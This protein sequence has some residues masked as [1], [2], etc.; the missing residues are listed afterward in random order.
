MNLE[1]RIGKLEA[2]I[3]DE[4]S[5]WDLTLLTDAELVALEACLS[6][7]VAAGFPVCLTPELEAAM[8]RLRLKP[9]ST[10]RL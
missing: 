4:P 2:S 7:A 10:A 5:A 8:A 6:E 3:G 1:T 9:R